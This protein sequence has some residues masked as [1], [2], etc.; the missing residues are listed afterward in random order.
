MDKLHV[1]EKESIHVFSNT[2]YLRPS[3]IRFSHDSIG[4][5]FG[6]Y[7]PHP[8]KPI[9]ETLDDILTGKINVN[10]IPT[11]SVYKKDGQWFTANNRRLW[12]LQEVEKRGKCCEIY[13]S[14]TTF[15]NLRIFTTT[16]K[17]VSVLVRGNPGGYFWQTMP[18][19]TMQ[20]NE[21]LASVP[22][23]KLPDL[24]SSFHC[25]RYS[26]E[27]DN[28]EICA[29]T[30][31]RL[32]SKTVNVDDN[33]DNIDVD[34]DFSSSL[35]ASQQNDIVWGFCHQYGTAEPKEN[36]IT[37]ETT[38]EKVIEKTK[39]T[40][41]ELAVMNGPNISGIHENNTLLRPNAGASRQLENRNI[42][43]TILT[44]IYGRP[45]E[46]PIARSFHYWACFGFILIIFFI[47]LWTL[48]ICQTAT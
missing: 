32:D 2:M 7:T 48:I 20:S 33:V 34:D 29:K 24:P 28:D 18:I 6:R 9:G 47:V 36:E 45:Y 21:P 37:G 4:R 25:Q 17:G 12:V 26:E 44:I 8:Y 5:T 11:I 31:V 19:K 10:S 16:N 38:I 14:E 46:L 40:D 35:E 42:A 41:I 23:T 39:K 27:I 43:M 13:V 15:V 1:S 3:E 30:S 22:P